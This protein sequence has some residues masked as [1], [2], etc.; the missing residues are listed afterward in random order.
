MSLVYGVLRQKQHL[1]RLLSQFCRQ[2]IT[3]L[4]PTVYQALLVG[5]FQLS[6]LERIPVSAAVNETVNG[7]RLAGVPKKLV[8]FING[9]LRE[10]S[11]QQAN[12]PLVNDPLPS[13][14]PVL[15]HPQWMTKRWSTRFGKAE[16]E[17]ICHINNQEPMLVLRTNTTRTSREQLLAKFTQKERVATPG[18]YAPD[19]IILPD[20]HGAIQD[21]PGFEEG[22]FQIQDEAAQLATLLLGPFKEQGFY[23]DGC[24][25]LGGKTSHLAQL[26]AEGNADLVA[27][28]PEPQRRTLLHQNLQRLFPKKTFTVSS[29]N[30]QQFSNE[31]DT[32][33]DGILLDVPCSGTG[34]T[35]RHP[36]IRW[37]RTL[38]DILNY[39][40]RQLELLRH[41]ARLLLPGGVIVYCTCSLEEEENRGVVQSFLQ[42]HPDFVLTDC[43][44]Y[45]PE[46]AVHLVSD[47]CFAPHPGG[48]IDG[49]F[50]AR[51][52]YRKHS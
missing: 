20:Y 14:K 13:G 46:S 48:S 5:L 44:A 34:V 38:A 25:G 1:E 33:F 40:T 21:L 15:N 31:R 8:G 4:H 26:L 37:N 47:K 45:L 22:E 42:Q 49:F 18:Q 30:L 43:A 24:A 7:A 50:A 35:G 28:E 51:M 32:L 3:K 23:L 9:V 11:R 10:A 39:P 41:S 16:M 36:D 17:R 6:S 29:S 27:V 12:L 2:K 19:S 52:E